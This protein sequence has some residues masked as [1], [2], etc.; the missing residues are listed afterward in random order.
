MENIKFFPTGLSPFFNTRSTSKEYSSSILTNSIHTLLDLYD[1][2]I[3]I[4]NNIE[5]EPITIDGNSP[6]KGLP[7]IAAKP[8]PTVAK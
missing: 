8:N 3:I 2:S 4:E 6:N 1:N 7:H 5:F